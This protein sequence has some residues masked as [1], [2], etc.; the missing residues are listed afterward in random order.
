MVSR[1]EPQGQTVCS[2]NDYRL[3]SVPEWNRSLS[4]HKPEKRAC[5]R[6]ASGLFVAETFIAL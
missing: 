6:R 3:L 5:D 1:A 2:E 4:G